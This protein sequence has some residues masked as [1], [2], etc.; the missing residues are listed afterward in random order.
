MEKFH[1]IIE[2]HMSRDT[3]RHMERFFPSRVI[4][5]LQGP[6]TKIDLLHFDNFLKFFNDESEIAV[7][8][9]LS[10]VNYDLKNLKGETKI[11]NLPMHKVHVF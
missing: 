4:K 3:S 11:S 1:Q 8:K 7:W 6:S 9:T 10:N 2:L 5:S